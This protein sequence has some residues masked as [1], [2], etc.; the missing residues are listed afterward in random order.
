MQ[1]KSVR[2]TFARR[3]DGDLTG[4]FGLVEVVVVVVVVV[5]VGTDKDL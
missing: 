3:N 4:R 1:A 2:D 5:V